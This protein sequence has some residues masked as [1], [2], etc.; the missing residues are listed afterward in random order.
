MALKLFNLNGIILF[1][2]VK[3][4]AGLQMNANYLDFHSHQQ[5]LPSRERSGPTYSLGLGGKE[6]NV[7]CF[8]LEQ[9]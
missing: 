4:I 6:S 9:I 7:V 1:Q 5:N 8:K 3:L 2:I